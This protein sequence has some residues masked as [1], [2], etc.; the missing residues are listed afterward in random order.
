MNKLSFVD[1]SASYKNNDFIVL[2]DINLTFKKGEMVAILG[3]SGAGKSTLFNAILHQVKSIKGSLIID[4][5][6]IYTINKRKL[7]KVLN[8]V[9]F[10][11]Q[12]PNLIEELNVYENIINFYKKYK[13]PFFSFFKIL[14][15]KQ[16]EEIYQTLA[17]LG[18]LGKAYTPIK[19]LSGGQKQ[20]VEI[21]KLFLQESEIILADEPT[22]SLDIKNSEDVFSLLNNAAKKQNKLVLVNVHDL[23]LIDKYFDRI[24]FIKDGKVNFE[25]KANKANIAKIKQFLKSE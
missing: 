17:N 5:K 23:S 3:K 25:G 8:Q 4:D 19:S 24:V 6:D 14:T 7:K 12:E 11:A 1:F 20:R 10:L 2:Q 16:K 15:K 9:G 18:I 13:N 22:S 21:A